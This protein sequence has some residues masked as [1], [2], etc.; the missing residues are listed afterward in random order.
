MENYYLYEKYIIL[1]IKSVIF[2]SI[3]PIV[4]DEINVD[5]IVQI[6]IRHKI[7]NMVYYSIEKLGISNKLSETRHLMAMKLDA[8]QMYYFESIS[9]KFKKEKIPYLPMKGLVIKDLYRFFG[10]AS[11]NGFRYLC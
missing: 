9:S 4:P 6:S 3:P 7:D 8:E 10:Y 11:V 5:E 2:G 1:L